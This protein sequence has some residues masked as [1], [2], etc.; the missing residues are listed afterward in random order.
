MQPTPFFLPAATAHVHLA[1]AL[2][3]LAQL[4]TAVL[5]V[6]E[7]GL[8]RAARLRCNRLVPALA[9]RTKLRRAPQADALYALAISRHAAVRDGARG[10]V[11]GILRCEPE[12]QLYRAVCFTP[13]G[14]RRFVDFKIDRIGSRRHAVDSLVACIAHGI[15]EA[16]IARLIPH[17]AK[18][19]HCQRGAQG[20]QPKDPEPIAPPPTDSAFHATP[21]IRTTLAAGTKSIC[22]PSHIR[23]RK[24]ALPGE[25]ILGGWRRDLCLDEPA[26]SVRR[27]SA[28]PADLVCLN[29]ATAKSGKLCSFGILL[30]SGV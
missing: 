2:P 9:M 16:K 17:A 21:Q 11:M 25:Q 23:L 6:A 28:S 15:F 13:Q 5:D 7:A 4:G 24:I 30:R 27:R 22:D 29:T 8:V 1:V 12:L 3:W 18:E 19:G 26:Q 14:W 20:D 10:S